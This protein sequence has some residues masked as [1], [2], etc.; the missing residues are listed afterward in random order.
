[1]FLGLL[2]EQESN[3]ASATNTD[4][5]IFRIVI[6]LMTMALY[7]ISGTQ[8]TSRCT[9]EFAKHKTLFVER[10]NE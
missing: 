4:I 9:S 8:V 10:K 1:L 5:D 6:R 2:S 7:F 3:I